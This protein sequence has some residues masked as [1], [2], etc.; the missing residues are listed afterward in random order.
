MIIKRHNGN[1]TVGVHQKC[2]DKKK[3]LAC[4]RKHDVP[5][6]FIISRY[7]E[8]IDDYI[9]L[10]FPFKSSAY[11]NRRSTMDT[12]YEGFSPDEYYRYKWL[13]K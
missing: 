2:V 13:R 7:F 10:L 12:C 9:V 5:G 11:K 6:R 8:G 4:K 1:F 3:C